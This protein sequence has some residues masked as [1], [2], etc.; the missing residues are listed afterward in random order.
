MVRLL[1]KRADVFRQNEISSPQFPAA[2]PICQPRTSLISGDQHYLT[3]SHQNKE[4]Y[5]MRPR[6]II[7]GY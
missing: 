3:S 2:I 4:C 5:E 6:V 7:R 1:L